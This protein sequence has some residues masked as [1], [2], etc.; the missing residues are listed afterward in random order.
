M[1]VKIDIR[2][3]P[4]SKFAIARARKSRDRVYLGWSLLK[5]FGAVLFIVAGLFLAG[6]Q[7]YGLLVSTRQELLIM[8]LA[9]GFLLFA[10]ITFMETEYVHKDSDIVGS[11]FVEINHSL[12]KVIIGDL[13]NDPEIKKYWESVQKQGRL[14]IR[15][16]ID[17]M[18]NFTGFK[19]HQ[20]MSRYEGSYLAG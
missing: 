11:K 20:L 10:L 17:E 6:K 19:R 7:Y 9:A 18:K 4:I 15:A 13:A 5:W 12:A 16:E 14:L 1:M 2:N 8:L 3:K